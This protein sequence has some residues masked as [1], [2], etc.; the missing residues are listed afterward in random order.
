MSLDISHILNEWPYKPGQVTARRIRGRDG[1]EKIQL[2]VDLGLLQMDATGRPD[3]QRPHGYDS[4]LTYHEHRLKVRRQQ[5]GSDEGFS[6]D[7]RDCELLRNEA[8]MYYHRYLAEFVLGDY[9]D[10]ERDTARNLRLMD[11]CRAY[12]RDESDR[13]LLEQY[14]PYVLMMFARARGHLALRD[15]RPKAALAIVRKG[16]ADIEAFYENFGGEQMLEHSGEVAVLRAMEK[17]IEAKVP[18]DPIQKLRAQLAQAVKDERY[19]LAAHLRD[20]LRRL[21]GQTPRA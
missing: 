16:I 5:H 13:Y 9:E 6:L 3:G 11:L 12:A 18:V 8:V 17:E 7:E 14:R 20:Q 4:L 2:R 15:N 10:V 21:S 19:E 1:R